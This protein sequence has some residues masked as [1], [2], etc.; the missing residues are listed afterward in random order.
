MEIMLQYLPTMK[1]HI[2]EELI[3][4]GNRG[5]IGQSLIK[6]GQSEV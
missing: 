3:L 6:N 5:L 2:N 4:T 1:L